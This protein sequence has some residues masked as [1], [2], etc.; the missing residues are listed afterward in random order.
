MRFYKSERAFFIL[1]VLMA[2]IGALLYRTRLDIEQLHDLPL[3]TAASELVA[4]LGQWNHVTIW[5]VIATIA[6]ALLSVYLHI[7]VATLPG[8]G[9]LD[10]VAQDRTGRPDV[11]DYA[12]LTDSLTGMQNRRYFDEALKEYLAQFNRIQRPVGLMIIDLDRFRT[13]NDTHGRNIGDVVLREVA[14]CLRDHTRQH[15]VV[16]RLGGEEFAI[17]ARN[18]DA[19]RMTKLADRIRK[20]ISLLEIDLGDRKLGVTASV[21]L[22]IWHRGETPK[23]FY[24]RADK[25]LDAAK[26]AG[27]NRVC[28]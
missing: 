14:G 21:G 2:A 24:R 3:G 28:V 17:L 22:A 8:R 13:I 26:G 9:R 18:M 6:C 11:F 5:A 16:A 7:V 23:N 25:M 27:R 20:A 15:D 10:F 1:I 4:T 19:E 12:A